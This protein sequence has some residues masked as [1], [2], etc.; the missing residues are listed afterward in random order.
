MT[1]TRVDALLC[2][3][4]GCDVIKTNA[5]FIHDLSVFRWDQGLPLLE[6][7]GLIFNLTGAAVNIFF[8]HQKQRWQP[9][10]W[11]YGYSGYRLKL[12]LGGPSITVAFHSSLSISKEQLCAA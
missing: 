5:I 3:S 12:I 9:R 2:G 1:T 7:R 8:K 4:L 6:L 10:Q 11:A